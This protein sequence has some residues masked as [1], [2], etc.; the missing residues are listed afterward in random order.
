VT[1]R[2]EEGLAEA[3]R[4]YAEGLATVGRRRRAF[5]KVT[6]DV[7][8]PTLEE[9]C[10][11]LGASGLEARTKRFD[12]R[13]NA[14]DVEFWLMASPTGIVWQNKQGEEIRGVERSAAMGYGQGDDGRVAHWRYG[15]RLDDEPPPPSRVLV[16]YQD[17][18]EITR[19]VVQRHV[20]DFLSEAWETSFRGPSLPPDRPIGFTVP[21]STEEE[22]EER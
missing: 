21:A 12:D 1:V 9:A 14:R 2:W 11:I 6:D 17:P 13:T 16:V 20:L 7:L 3:A 4:R 22:R 10:R 8:V 5:A 15:H 18:A 19:D